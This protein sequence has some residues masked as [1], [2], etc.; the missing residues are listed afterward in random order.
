MFPD[1]VIEN[2]SPVDLYKGNTR[3]CCSL[4]KGRLSQM[5]S[6]KEQEGMKSL[7]N[8]TSVSES[9][10]ILNGLPWWSSGWESTCQCRE[11]RFDLWS[12]KIPRATGQP[13][14]CS[15]ATEARTPQSLCSKGSQHMRS[16]CTATGESPHA[17]AKTQHSQKI[18]LNE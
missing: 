4:G 17:A 6:Q 18:I 12:R 9:K 1:K 5:E 13:S 15:T 10:W 3:G 11:H 16:P 8:G 14:P 7:E 2:L